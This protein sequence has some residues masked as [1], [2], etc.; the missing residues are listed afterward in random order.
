[1]LEF[2]GYKLNR[3][4]FEVNGFLIKFRFKVLSKSGIILGV[5]FQL[6]EKIVKFVLDGLYFKKFQKLYFSVLHLYVFKKII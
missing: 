5:V 2:K 6:H 4:D 1:M 3:V